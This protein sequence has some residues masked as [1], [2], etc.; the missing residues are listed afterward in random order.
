MTHTGRSYG[1]ETDIVPTDARLT[2][3]S[4]TPWYAMLRDGRY[5]YI[6]TL[7]EGET[8]EVYDLDADP[9][10][11][12]NLA[13]RPEHRKLLETLRTKA[14]AELKRTDAAFVDRM[15]PTKAMPAAR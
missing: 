15:P 6:R 13:A 1:S 12:M 9:E 5:K 2:D 14:V 4:N 11:L 10:E 7:I 8:E 3:S